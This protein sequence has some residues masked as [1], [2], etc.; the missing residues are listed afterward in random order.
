MNFFKIYFPLCF[1][2][3]NPLDPPASKKFFKQNLWFYFGLEL[4]IQANM[5]E[6]S[7]AFFEVVIETGLTL[8]FVG[9]ILFLN[10]SLHQYIAIA[11][12][13]LFCENIVAIFGVPVVIWLTVS[14]SLLSYYLLG[15]LILWDYILITYIVKHVLSINTAASLAISFFYFLMTYFGAYGITLLLF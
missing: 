13:V 8:C 10:K 1:L 6:P 12:A 11:S 7:E 5:I 4:F 14:E 9:L 15:V 3:L 2:K